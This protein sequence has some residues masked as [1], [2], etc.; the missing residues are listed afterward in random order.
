MKTDCPYKRSPSGG[1]ALEIQAG[2]EVEWG[3]AFDRVRGYR[4]FLGFKDSHGK[5]TLSAEAA[6]KC[7]SDIDD[8][9]EQNS[10][11]AGNLRRMADQVDGLNRGWEAA[12]KP[13]DGIDGTK[14]GTA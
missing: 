11:L 13:A 6:R 14:G 8:G 4:V 2:R 1:W 10:H 3:H 7:A 5:N 12:G 9:S